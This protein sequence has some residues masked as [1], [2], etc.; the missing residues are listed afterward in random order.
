MPSRRHLR[1]DLL[2]RM[3]GKIEGEKKKRRGTDDG[4][5]TH[6]LLHGKRVV[7]SAR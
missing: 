1:R 4:I 3:M 5:R 7:G 6:D 2:K